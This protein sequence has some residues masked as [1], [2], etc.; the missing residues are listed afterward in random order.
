MKENLDGIYI[1]NSV[2]FYCL[3]F[4]GTDSCDG[5]TLQ[6][7]L[8]YLIKKQSSQQNLEL[9]QILGILVDMSQVILKDQRQ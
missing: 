2:L 6:S 1:L 4:A 5:E 9:A 3:L 7:E 8:N